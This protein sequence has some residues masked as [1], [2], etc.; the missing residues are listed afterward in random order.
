MEYAD[1]NDPAPSDAAG[2][3]APHHLDLR[4]L[5]HRSRSG[6]LRRREGTC[7]SSSSERSKRGSEA[8]TGPS[9]ELWDEIAGL[10]SAMAASNQTPDRAPPC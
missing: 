8:N 5:G 6:V 10:R 2:K 1:A 9:G 7:L 4:K 3:T